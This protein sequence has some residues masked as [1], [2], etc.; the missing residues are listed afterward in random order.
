MSPPGLKIY[1]G[2]EPL[3]IASVATRSISLTQNSTHEKCLH[4]SKLP[5]SIDKRVS[6]VGKTSSWLQVRTLATVR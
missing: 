6:L 2:I 5:L 1:T 4:S 3:T